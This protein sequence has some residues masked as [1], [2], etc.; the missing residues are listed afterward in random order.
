MA[1]LPRRY[2]KDFDIELTPDP[3]PAN[4]KSKDKA[5]K[6]R[7]ALRAQEKEQAKQAKQSK[8]SNKGPKYD[9][10]LYRNWMIIFLIIA[11]IAS[12]FVYNHMQSSSAN[13]ASAARIVKRDFNSKKSNITSSATQS[14][15]DKLKKNASKIKNSDKANYYSQL[16]KAGTAALSNQDK[17][18]NLKNDAGRY[19]TSVTVAKVKS[20]QSQ[21]KSGNLQERLPDFYSTTNQ[22]YQKLI[23]PVTKVQSL[24]AKVNKLYNKKGKLKSS[25][26]VDKVNKLM[27]K[28]GKY[29]DSYQLSYK[30]FK[31]LQKAQKTAQKNKEAESASESTSNVDKVESGSSSDS[32]KLTS[33]S[34][35]QNTTN[36]SNTGQSSYYGSGSTGTTSHYSG[37]GHSSSTISA[38][39]STSTSQNHQSSTNSNNQITGEPGITGSTDGVWFRQ[40]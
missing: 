12:F 2:P 11:V 38:S 31:K 30:D 16:A 4:S 23:K 27:D 29:M 32:G 1:E 9:W 3:K 40:Y 17:Y 26:S 5:P 24:H 15:M 7:M 22:K 36:S 21:L 18:Q 25:V 8:N 20:L 34:N 19:K 13:E 28:V 10:K 6:S 33:P 35:S 39:T 37:G 14:D